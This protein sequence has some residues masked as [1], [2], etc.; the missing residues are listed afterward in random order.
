MPTRKV[1]W[2]ALGAVPVW[3][4]AL[5]L[6]GRRSDSLEAQSEK[7]PRPTSPAVLVKFSASTDDSDAEQEPP[8]TPT[9]AH[10]VRETDGLLSVR[11]SFYTTG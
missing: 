2:C 1:A 8:G 5:R 4:V 11:L 6:L 3:E 10:P 9:K 7:E